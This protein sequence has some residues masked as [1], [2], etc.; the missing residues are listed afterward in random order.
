MPSISNIPDPE[1][2]VVGSICFIITLLENIMEKYKV[3]L[4]TA[5]SILHDFMTLIIHQ[6]ERATNDD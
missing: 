5:G 6:K 3:P 2:D 1:K 4:D